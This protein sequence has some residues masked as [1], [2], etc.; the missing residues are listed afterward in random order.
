MQMDGLI[1]D[2]DMAQLNYLVE[3]EGEEP[4]DVATDFLAERG[5]LKE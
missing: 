2:E 3:V 4:E 1:S 5:L